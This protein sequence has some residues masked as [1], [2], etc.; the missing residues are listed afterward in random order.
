MAIMKKETG[1]DGL[2]EKKAYEPPRAMH[3][4]EMRNGAGACFGGSG[5]QFSCDLSGNSASGEC[6]DSGN[7]VRR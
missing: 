1:K 4:G 7:S 6:M 5:D 2:N 3:L